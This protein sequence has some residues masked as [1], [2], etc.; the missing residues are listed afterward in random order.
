MEHCNYSIEYLKELFYKDYP[1]IPSHL[2]KNII[3]K[4][5]EDILYFSRILELYGVKLP[6]ILKTEMYFDFNYE[7][8]DFVKDMEEHKFQPYYFIF[9]NLKEYYQVY[10]TFINLLTMNDYDETSYV[11]ISCVNVYYTDLEEEFNKTK[12]NNK[13]NI[14]EIVHN[15]ISGE[16]RKIVETIIKPTVEDKLTYG[17]SFMGFDEENDS[18]NVYNLVE[19]LQGENFEK[20]YLLKLV[21]IEGDIV[22]KPIYTVKKFNE[23]FLERFSDYP[24]N[25]FTIKDY[26]KMR[27]SFEDDFKFF[28]EK[29]D[30]N[31][32]DGMTFEE[33]YNNQHEIEKGVDDYV[34]NLFLQYYMMYH[35]FISNLQINL[36]K[37]CAC[38]NNA[39]F[40]ILKEDYKWLVNK[41]RDEIY[42]TLVKGKLKEMILFTMFE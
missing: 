18:Y 21:T 22:R 9:K 20:L 5:N 42:N 2:R 40:N 11:F 7:K 25:V 3:N 33:L 24:K 28:I 15:L 12:P 17:V 10:N 31:N 37:G 32:E 39:M 14:C 27:K 1:I 38:I 35:K 4:F 16:T 8:S 6:V 23:L 26:Q 34:F 36:L 41:D 19:I 30:I 29:F 13:L